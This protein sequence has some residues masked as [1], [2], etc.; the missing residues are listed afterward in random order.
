MEITCDDPS[1]CRSLP[2]NEYAITMAA[3]AAAS[4]RYS[5]GTMSKAAFEDLEKATGFRYNPHGL[6]Q[7]EAL[8]LLAN[9]IEVAAYDW[10][11]SVLQ[12][13][14][15]VA[16]IEAILSATTMSREALQAFLADKQWQFPRCN[17]IKSRQLHRIF[18]PR[19]LIEEA[20]NKVRGSCAEF[21]SLYGMLRCFVALQLGGDTDFE[22]HVASFNAVCCIVDCILD[23]KQCLVDVRVGADRLEAAVRR[24][25]ALHTGVYG[26]V[27]IRPKHHWMLDVPQQFRRDGAVLDAFVIERTHLRVKA[28]AEPI[29]NVRGFERSAL[30]S[31]LTTTLQS[32]ELPSD[33][34]LG[35]SA[36]LPGA[37]L[38]VRVADRLR[39]WGTEIA[40]QDVVIRNGSAAWVAACALDAGVLTLLVYPLHPTQAVSEHCDMC[41][42]H[43]ELVAWSAADVTLALA[44]RRRGDGSFMVVRK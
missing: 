28:V 12:G 26:D 34:L 21:L 24:H 40:F 44:W 1:L 38:F 43:S 36:P 10:V 6:G 20:P 32:K 30:A 31:L 7:S 39:V 3:V 17:A 9:P 14:I 13:G 5:A 19:R 16:E 37:A 23:V 22:R 25:L 35:R 41:Q 42:L 27:Y 11:H 8:Q 4:R 15:L 18:D 2:P 33:G 29:K